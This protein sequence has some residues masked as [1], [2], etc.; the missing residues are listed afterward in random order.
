[1]LGIRL[2]NLMERKA[3]S[4]CT[5]RPFSVPQ[6]SIQRALQP[7]CFLQPATATERDE[8]FDNVCVYV[9]SSPP[10]TDGGGFSGKRRQQPIRSTG[11][12]FSTAVPEPC[13]YFDRVDIEATTLTRW[14]RNKALL[15]QIHTNDCQF[16]CTSYTEPPFSLMS[17]Y[18]SQQP[19]LPR[20]TGT[21]GRPSSPPSPSEPRPNA[22]VTTTND[23]Q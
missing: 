15:Y 11:C 20:H 1:M 7:F 14:S 4:Q 5:S 23:K 16:T 21:S 19:T 22:T 6:L 8:S 18:H 10:G 12:N 17:L 2:G 3:V 13:I 9:C